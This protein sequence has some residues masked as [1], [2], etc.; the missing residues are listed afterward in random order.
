MDKLEDFIEVEVLIFYRKL[1]LIFDVKAIL[2][3]L[4]EGFREYHTDGRILL[5]ANL[6][7]LLDYKRIKLKKEIL[8]QGLVTIKLARLHDI[9]RNVWGSVALGVHQ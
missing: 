5:L 6:S 2:I 1:D 8:I 7:K 3:T 4:L 9:L